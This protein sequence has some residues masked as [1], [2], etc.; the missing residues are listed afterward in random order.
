MTLKRGDEQP[1]MLG[2]FSHD[3]FAEGDSIRQLYPP[4]PRSIAGI[5]TEG[6]FSERVSRKP[7]QQLNQLM[8]LYHQWQV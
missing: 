3:E 5:K 8:A 4:M 6:R 2:D 7:R 1:F